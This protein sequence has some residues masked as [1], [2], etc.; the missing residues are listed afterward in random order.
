MTASPKPGKRGTPL[1]MAITARPGKITAD[2]VASGST[3]G[4]GAGRIA[5]D[6]Q[7]LLRQARAVAGR[8]QCTGHVRHHQLL[9]GPGA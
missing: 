9:E 4:L 1:G 5:Q 3:H 8:H 2:P 7:Q 6:A